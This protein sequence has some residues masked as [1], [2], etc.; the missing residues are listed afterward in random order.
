MTG[1]RARGKYP[2]NDSGPAPPGNRTTPIQP[3][4]KP[5]NTASL[6][7]AVGGDQHATPAVPCMSD[8]IRDYLD[9]I[10]P[11]DATGWLHV[12]LG[13]D[14]HL[15]EHGKYAHGSWIAR[16]RSSGPQQADEAIAWIE[17]SAPLGD[18]YV[19]PYLMRDGKRAKGNAAG[20]Q[21]VHSDVDN[22]HLDPDEV[23]R[24]RRVRVRSGSPGNGHVYI[25]LAH[26]VTAGPARDPVPRPGRPPRRRPRQDQRQRRAAAARHA[27]PQGRLQRRRPDP[28]GA[29]GAVHRRQG[30]PARA[31]RRARCRHHQHRRAGQRSRGRRP[32]SRTEPNR[33]TWTPTH[34]WSRRSPSSPSRPTGRWTPTASSRPASTT[35]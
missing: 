30:R 6:S 28:C 19:C 31:G 34:R 8:A 16:G 25:V 5:P 35:A 15:D 23:E 27:Q 9:A 14:P 4:P 22:G 32:R 13:R 29:G 33:S 7:G 18:V 12:A 11:A 26:A 17:R 2:R 10:I 20:R 3:P 1:P 24:A 21:L